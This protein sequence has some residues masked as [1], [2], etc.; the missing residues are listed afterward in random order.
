MT[1]LP[2][3]RCGELMD[4]DIEGYN[5]LTVKFGPEAT[6]ESEDVIVLSVKEYELNVA[7]FIYEYVC[8]LVP[9]RHVHEEDQNGNIACNPDTLKQLE[10][11]I[12]HEEEAEE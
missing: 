6:E 9:M 7:Q 4:L 5:E 12:H 2:C 11:F 3:D 10:K 8:L 1:T